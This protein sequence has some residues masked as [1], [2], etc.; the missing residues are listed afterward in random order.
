MAIPL[1]DL[2]IG[3]NRNPGVSARLALYAALKGRELYV[4]T[5]TLPSVTSGEKA[6]LMLPLVTAE[7]REGRKALL[8]FCDAAEIA[9][10]EGRL[11]P[12]RL[13][14]ADAMRVVLAHTYEALVIRTGTTWVGIPREDSRHVL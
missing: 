14:V 4:A 8:A 13:T 3:F 6:P 1:S 5:P 12:L 9:S 2:I 11:F 7:T 10:L